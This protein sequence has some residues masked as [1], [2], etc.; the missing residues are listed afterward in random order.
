MEILAE[1]Q[2]SKDLYMIIKE[3]TSAVISVN[4]WLKSYGFFK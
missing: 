1:N 3:K 2:N 4:L